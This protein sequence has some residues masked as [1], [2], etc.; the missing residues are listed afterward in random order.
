MAG[1]GL[2]GVLVA[3]AGPGTVIALDAGSYAASV[4]ALAS[5]RLPA[6]RRGAASLAARSCLDD[7]RDGWAEFRG[8]PGS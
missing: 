1:P 2:A 8:R 3:L 7:L 5:L 4:L 6:A